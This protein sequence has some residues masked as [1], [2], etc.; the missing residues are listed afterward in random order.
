MFPS[1]P[2]RR[3]RTSGHL[4]LRR[5]LGA[6]GTLATQRHRCAVPSADRLRQRA[7]R[8]APTAAPCSPGAFPVPSAP[9]AAAATTSA[10]WR[11]SAAH[12]AD[13]FLA[14][15]SHLAEHL[16][17]SPIARRTYGLVKSGRAQGEPGATR[18][19]P[20]ARARRG[21]AGVRRLRL[22][23]RD[24]TPARGGDRPVPRRDLPPLRRQGRAV[25]RAR[26]GGRRGGRDPGRRLRAGR[27]DA[28]A[29]RQGRRLARACSSRSPA[30]SAPTRQFAALWQHHLRSITR[31]TQARLARQRD[32]GFVR[33]DVPIETLAAFLLLAYDGLVAQLATGMPIQHLDG[34][35]DLAEQAVRDTPPNDARSNAGAPQMASSNSFDARSTL[36]V[37]GRDVTI[38]RLD[39]VE[40]SARCCRTASRCCWRT[41][42]ATR[43]ATTSPPTR[44]A[45]SPAGTPTPSPTPRSSS[46]PLASSCRTSPACPASSTSP[47]CA[48]RWQTLGGDPKKIN[49]L[50]PDRA[51][52][53]PL[54]DRRRLRRARRLREERRAGVRAQPGAL[55]VPALGPERVRRLQ[56]RPAGHRHRPP[57]Q[58]RVPR[59]GRV[60]SRR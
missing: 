10:F 33:D 46:P 2:R 14:S 40:G 32:A 3:H 45:R 31:A 17:T 1:L 59:P 22:R 6:V 60:R 34:V 36:I 37:G 41:C 18:S 38:Y 16:A 13:Q 27:R 4:R 11:R 8:F 23:G 7:T 20:P 48:R 51:G 9:S 25:P 19:D 39:A 28:Q 24:R 50:V 42:S 35:L 54:G 58:P 29:A 43:T 52:H 26:R 56:G 12:A 30:G 44:C 57:G 53:R 21:P 55:P 5:R 15:A 49:P 47:R